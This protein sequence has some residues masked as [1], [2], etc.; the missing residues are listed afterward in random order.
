MRRCDQMKHGLIAALALWP[1]AAVAEGMPMKVTFTLGDTAL[2]A[3]L[4][5]SPAGRDFAS[6]LPLEVMLS[7]YHGI[8]KVADLGRK[9]DSTGMPGRYTPQA[10]DITQYA[11]W[12]NLALFLKP[13]QASAGLVRIGQFDGDFAALSRAG[14][15]RIERVD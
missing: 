12:S 8:E 3:T 6:M 9:L 15:V 5:D 1:M 13:F 10:G 2:I 4:D 11:P 14:R 7:D